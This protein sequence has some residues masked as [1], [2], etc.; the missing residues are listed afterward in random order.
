MDA[1]ISMQNVNHF[2]GSG[3]LRK[4]VLFDVSIEIQAGEIVILTGPS[5]SGKTTLLTLAGALRTVD[6]GSVRVLQQELK[7]ASQHALVR[8]RKQIGFIFQS[9]NLLDALTACQNVQ[10]SLGRKHNV[11]AA[12]VQKK[13]ETILGAVGLGERIHSL[14]EHLSGGQRQ[15]VAIARALVREPKIILADEPT[16]ALDRK[17]GREVVELLHHLAKQQGCA[18]LLVTHDNRILDIADRIMMLEDGRIASFAS[19]IMVNTGNLLAAFAQ[20][21]RKGELVRHVRSLSDKQFLELLEQIT[22]EFGQF[23][24]SI[25]FGNQEAVEALFD[26]VLE[27]VTLKI[28]EMLGADRATIFLVDEVAGLLRSRIA[29][30]NTEKPLVIEIPISTGVAGRVART[31]QAVNIPDPYNHPDFNRSVDRETGYLTRQILCMPIHDRRRRVFAVAQLLN[32]KDGNP[33]TTE[34]EKRFSDFAEPLGVILESCGRL[35]QDPVVTRR[36][37]ND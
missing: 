6:E 12:V 27:S 9:H 33:F 21:Q 30:G 22:S 10:M 36:R 2:Y 14:P 31:N 5:G 35:S 1:V 37:A 8:V 24:R 15:R 18:I 23:L 11:A 7:G 32:R 17:S 28:R 34:D 29:H 3:A 16:A 19:G 25:E 4:Q 26:Q 13:C 20:L